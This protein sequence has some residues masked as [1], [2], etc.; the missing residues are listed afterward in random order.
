MN[1]PFDQQEQSAA[2]TGAGWV[3]HVVLFK[4]RAGTSGDAVQ[5]MRTGLESLPETIPGILDLSCGENFCDRAK[6]MN[7]GLVV[8]F[9]SERALQ[10]YVH[11]ADHVRVVETLVQPIVDDVLALD[12]LH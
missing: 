5:A 10:L 9:E 12:Y 2:S 6:G 1:R 7:F 4:I 11:H 8:R 3:E